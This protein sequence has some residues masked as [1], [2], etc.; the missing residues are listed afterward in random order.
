MTHKCRMQG[1]MMGCAFVYAVD[2]GGLVFVRL[3]EVRSK[4]D[5]V[6]ISSS[7]DGACSEVS[8]FAVCECWQW[9][10]TGVCR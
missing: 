8:D 9:R 6:V 4:V 5:V 1:R 3:L 10:F 7:G 2:D